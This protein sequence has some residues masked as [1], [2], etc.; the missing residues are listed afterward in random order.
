MPHASCRN[1]RKQKDGITESKEKN[2][3]EKVF[4]ASFLV[5]SY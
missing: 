2:D 3:R 1:G 4:L 5:K